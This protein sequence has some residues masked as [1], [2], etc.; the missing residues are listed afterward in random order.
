MEGVQFIL[1]F[2]FWVFFD[3]ALPTFLFVHLN[4]GKLQIK[5]KVPHFVLLQESVAFC[6]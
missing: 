4:V 1:N 3:L 6:L 2:L 5:D